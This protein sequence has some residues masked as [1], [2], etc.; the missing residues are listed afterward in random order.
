[1]ATNHPRSYSI[2]ASQIIRGLF[3]ENSPESSLLEI[4]A[5]G[6][7]RLI[8]KPIEW[9]KILWLLINTFKNPEG[10]PLILGAKLGE[11]QKALPVEFR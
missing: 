4:A 8:A 1:M 2:T 9:N 5:C 3:D 6:K 7:I 10:Q 11:I